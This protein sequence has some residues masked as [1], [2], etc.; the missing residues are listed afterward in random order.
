M[1]GHSFGGYLAACYCEKYPEKIEHLTLL[2]PAGTADQL[3][4]PP[5]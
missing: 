1:V 3:T 2:S 5:E 4:H